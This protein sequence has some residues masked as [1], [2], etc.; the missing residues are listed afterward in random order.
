MARF[1]DRTRFQQTRNFGQFDG[2]DPDERRATL[3]Q[4]RKEQ[5]FAEAFRKA[6]RMGDSDRKIDILQK[7]EKSGVEFGGIRQAGD[8]Q[9]DVRRRFAQTK[10]LGQQKRGQLQR[11]RDLQK[12][13][14]EFKSRVLDNEMASLGLVEDMQEKLDRINNPRNQDGFFNFGKK[15]LLNA[16]KNM[17]GVDTN[18]R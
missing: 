1:G 3:M 6:R 7:A 4:R 17:F 9:D 14:D 18:F 10:F 12:Q 16:A 5:T 8:I 13:Q 15:S 11:T 2:G